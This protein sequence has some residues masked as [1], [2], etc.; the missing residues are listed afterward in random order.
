MKKQKAI[1]IKNPILRKFRNNLRLIIRLA[2]YDK[3]D[4]LREEIRKLDHIDK[5]D[6]GEFPTEDEE[7]KSRALKE[8]ENLLWFKIH[9]SICYVICVRNMIMIWFFS[10]I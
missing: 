7:K 10:S 9:K 4:K 2:V 5:Y 3:V 1:I 6:D 8:K